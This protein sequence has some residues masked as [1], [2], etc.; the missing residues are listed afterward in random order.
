MRRLKLFF[1]FAEIFLI[2][3]RQANRRYCCL[4]HVYIVHGSIKTIYIFFT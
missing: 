4:C 1:H 3:R 2:L